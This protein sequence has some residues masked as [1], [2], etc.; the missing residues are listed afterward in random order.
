MKEA[1]GELSTTVIAVVAIAAVLTIFVTFLLPSLR[2][3][4]RAR[5]YCS[6]SV[7]CSACTGGKQQC[8][9]YEE[10][11]DGS[12]QVSTNPITCDCD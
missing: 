5:T 4:L 1:T 12:L 7:D 10:Q 6:Q 11:A 2:A 3:G 8:Y 9:Y